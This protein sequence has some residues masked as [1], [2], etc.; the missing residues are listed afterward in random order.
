MC[1]RRDVS[2]L[3]H[4]Y[5]VNSHSV[6][7]SDVPIYGTDKDRGFLTLPVM[8]P[9]TEIVCCHTFE[10][11]RCI[12]S[13]LRAVPWYAG[14]RLMSYLP[15]TPAH[16]RKGSGKGGNEGRRREDRNK[17]KIGGWVMERKKRWGVS[18][19]SVRSGQRTGKSGREKEGVYKLKK[20]KGGEGKERREGKEA[21]RKRTESELEQG[22]GRKRRE[23][24]TGY[25][26]ARGG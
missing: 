15:V 16:E 2:K 13:Y 21:G 11:S 18:L 20:E 23:R 26:T 22:S 19:R 8:F 24:S 7:G 5:D 10:V 12:M 4:N 25:R 9:K 17:G 1:Q 3:R 14:R 6:R